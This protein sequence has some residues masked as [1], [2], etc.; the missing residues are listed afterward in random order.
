MVLWEYFGMTNN[1]VRLLISSP[2]L[3]TTYFGEHWQSLLQ[4]TGV[5]FYEAIMGLLLATIF[6]FTT[7]IICFYIPK[8]FDFVMPLMVISQ[9]IPLIV[10]APFFILLLGYGYSSKIAMATLISFFPIFVNFA[11]G[12]KSIPKEI[13]EYSYINNTS[14]W[15][16]IKNIYF[17]LSKTNIL[18]GLQI[19]SNLA[20]IGAL[21]AEFSGANMGL[22]RNIYISALRLEPELMMSS[23][24]LSIIIGLILYLSLS[25]IKKISK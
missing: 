3:L 4:A 17:P 16:K 6:S 9:I 2:S 5:T 13:I 7:M 25:F 10:L 11:T 20:I 23:L 22:G 15:T 19:A 1:T 18:T 14:T 21:I 8:F 12:V 24:F